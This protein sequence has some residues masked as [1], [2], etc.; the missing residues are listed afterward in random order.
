MNTR[1]KSGPISTSPLNDTAT[2][3]Q[4]HCLKTWEYLC[5]FLALLLML[6]HILKMVIGLIILSRN[7]MFSQS[8]LISLV[9]TSNSG[10]FPQK[11]AVHHIHYSNIHSMGNPTCLCWTC[12]L[13]KIFKLCNVMV[14]ATQLIDLSCNL[15][16]PFHCSH[17]T[18]IFE[19]KLQLFAHLA[20]FVSTV[21]ISLSTH[22]SCSFN[23]PSFKL[24][25]LIALT[26]YFREHL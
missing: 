20:V 23:V 8:P 21:F 12:G 7:L 10:P 9:V 18:I 11:V 4:D 19:K 24:G 16:Y 17:L 1:L 3:S 6:N 15:G 26:F 13:I 2:V 14:H 25:W 5:Q 22:H